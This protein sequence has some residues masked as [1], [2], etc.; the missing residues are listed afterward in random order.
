M[1]QAYA[2]FE[3]SSAPRRKSQRDG[4]N[5]IERKALFRLETELAAMPASLIVR[6][7]L[8][9]DDLANWSKENAIDPAVTYNMMANFKPYHRVRTL[10]ARRLGVSKEDLDRLIENQTLEPSAKIPPAPPEQWRTREDPLPT[11]ENA[12]TRP[13]PIPPRPASAKQRRDEVW[14]GQM[15]LDF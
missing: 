15:T 8:W 13:D 9:P 5:P 7:A 1:N 6:I 4:T 3:G 14:G 12:S 11:K 10:L 2:V